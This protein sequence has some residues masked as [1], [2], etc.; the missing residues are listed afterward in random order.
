MFP[1]NKCSYTKKNYKFPLYIILY[2]V[3][4][5]IILM[6]IYQ[7]FLFLSTPILG[8]LGLDFF[9]KAGKTLYLTLEVCLRG[10]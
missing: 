9:L 4:E 8:S 1:F 7:C 2:T 6:A 10:S 5:L 3:K